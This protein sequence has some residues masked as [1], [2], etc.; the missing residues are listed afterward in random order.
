MKTRLVKTRLLTA[1]LMLCML[2]PQVPM[3]AFAAENE[4]V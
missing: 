2:L 4:G 3:L 1:L